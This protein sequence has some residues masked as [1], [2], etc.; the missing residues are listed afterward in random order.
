MALHSKLRT[1]HLPCR[2][3]PRVRQSA[4][5]LPITIHSQSMC[6]E[7]QPRAWG[8]SYL[9]RHPDERKPLIPYE[10]G[11]HLTALAYDPP[12]SL[13]ED[14]YDW[15]LSAVD[16]VK[17]DL[18][19]LPPLEACLRHPPA[20]G[21]LETS[22][23]V[24]LRIIDHISVG[25]GRNSQ[26][27]KVEARGLREKADDGHTPEFNNSMSSTPM[28]RHITNVAAKLYDPL[29]WDFD[30]CIPDPFHNCDAAFSLETEAYRRYLRPLYGTLVPRFFGSYTIDVPI[31][32]DA[33]LGRPSGSPDHEEMNQKTLGA[34]A[35]YRT[36]PVRAI[37]YEYVPGVVLV[38]AMEN[39]LYSQSQRKEI[40]RALV[41]A[42]SRLRE[43][44]VLLRRDFHPRNVVVKSVEDGQPADIRIIDFGAALCGERREEEGHIP[45]TKPEPVEQILERWLDNDDSGRVSDVR[46]DFYD[47]VD[48]NWDE[49]LR[50]D[51]SRSYK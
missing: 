11:S 6:S 39:E 32:G 14:P 45:T 20:E 16:Q 7:D 46:Y 31:L 37:L 29:Y 3:V 10:I 23:P 2:L 12:K 36:R 21:R 27:V 30:D 13:L 38:H 24:Q 50:K 22:T 49:W 48:W 17:D 43:L 8:Y 4:K 15:Y 19:N 33:T 34:V 18:R 9:N 25:D 51:Y 26:V 40:M 1:L 5:R 28:S 44:D 47:L 42:E 35:Q 41:T